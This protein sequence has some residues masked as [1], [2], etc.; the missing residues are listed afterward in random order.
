MRRLLRLAWDHT[1]KSGRDHVSAGPARRLL[2]LQGVSELMAILSVLIVIEIVVPGPA[3]L[4]ALNPSPFWLPVLLITSQYGTASGLVSAICSIAA[5]WIGGLPEWS[6]SEDFYAYSLRLWRDPMLW[7]ATAVL[8]GELRSRHI[9]ER[10]RL[11]EK[12][13]LADQQRH[14]IAQYCHEL[15]T[16]VQTLERRIAASHDR[17]I[18]AG[19]SA[20]VRLRNCEAQNLRKGLA[21]AIELFL[22]PARYSVYLARHH[23]VVRSEL[24]EPAGLAQIAPGGPV[25]IRPEL[26]SAVLREHRTLCAMRPDQ[27]RLL[28]GIGL[29]AAPL[30]FHEN[31][32][33]LGM[34]V[35]EQVDAV[36]LGDNGEV[37]V[38]AICSALSHALTATSSITSIRSPRPIAQVVAAMPI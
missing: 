2:E 19:L 33:V 3:S 34:L 27:A 5:S 14:T 4:A 10:D 36:G 7:M 25:N 6:A 37:A 18:E 20:L 15:E 29:F 16:H 21:D 30:I 9:Q 24:S 23:H 32:K 17:S 31:Q 26:F 12:L 35:I 11:A 8:L 13:R 38:K 28:D 1:P 22:G